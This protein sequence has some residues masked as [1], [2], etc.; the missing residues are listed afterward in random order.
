MRC[1][2]CGQTLRCIKCGAAAPADTDTGSRSRPLAGS[3]HEEL[4]NRCVFVEIS[5]GVVRQ[6]LL[7][8]DVEDILERMT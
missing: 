7:L 5:K 3:I 4:R 1:T 6:V 8:N 2:K